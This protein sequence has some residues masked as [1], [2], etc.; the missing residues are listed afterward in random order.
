VGLGS[1]L[2][3]V[4]KRRTV[5]SSAT[6]YT[7]LRYPRSGRWQDNIKMNVCLMSVTIGESC[8]GNTVRNF[9]FSKKRGIS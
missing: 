6:R 2:D 8:I 3:A 9:G 4:K 1:V 7:R 5:Q